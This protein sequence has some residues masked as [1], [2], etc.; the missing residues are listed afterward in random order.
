MAQGDEVVFASGPDAE[1]AATERGLEFRTV[2]PAF[3]A[4]LD[5]LR[6]RTRGMPGDG[7]PPSRV[8]HYFLPRLFGEIG[9]AAM[10]DGLIEVCRTTDAEVLVFDPLVFAGPLAASVVGATPVQQTVGLLVDPGVAQLVTDA[11][12]PLWREFGRDVPPAAGMYDGVTVA[13]CPPSLD[14]GPGE[15][16]RITRMRPVP[17]PLPAAQTRSRL[18]EG[19]ALAVYVTLGTFSNNLAQFRILVDALATTSARF[20][21]TVGRDVDPRDLGSVPA[22]VRIE[23]FIP[24]AEVLPHCDAVIHHGGAG[25]TFGV[26]A[27]GIPSVVLPQS[28]DNFTIAE[29]LSAAGAAAVLL[30]E[31]WEGHDIQR[32]LDDVLDAAG[33][34]I[35]AQSLAG[36]IADMPSPATVAAELRHAQE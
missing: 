3:G 17:E 26:L 8:E 25:T 35:A 30:P 29:R 4:W 13:V 21:F 15:R 16:S 10:I 19:D 27:H 9:A 34:R 36:E 28:A 5:E 22:N 18:P 24:Q 12:S 7:L 14:P 23:Q 2:G 20:L 33:Y 31:Q 11:V 6:R 32:A 1:T